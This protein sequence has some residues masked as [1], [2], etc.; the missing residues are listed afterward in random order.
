MENSVNE[1]LVAVKQQLRALMNGVISASLREKG[2]KYRLIY[3]VEWPRLVALAQEI[4]QDRTLAAALWKEDIRE[5]R[6]LAG[7]LY[8]K[9]EFSIDLAEVWIESMQYP[10]EAQYTTMSLLQHLPNAKEVAF[11]WIANN[12]EMFQLCGFLVLAR[13]LHRLDNWSLRDSHEFLDQARCLKATASKAL[14]SAIQNAVQKHEDFLQ[15]QA[16]V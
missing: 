13:I 4:G 3:G 5:C 12:N 16:G 6:L 1:Q 2:L 10:E 11:R 9:E 8:P 7:L 15:E 14:R